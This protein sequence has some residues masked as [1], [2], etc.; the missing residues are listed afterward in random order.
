MKF[1]LAALATL[2]LTPST[3]A[4][5]LAE[6]PLS[7][8]ELRSPT[9]LCANDVVSAKIYSDS[10]SNQVHLVLENGP[11]SNNQFMTHEAVTPMSSLDGSQIF[12]SN[13]SAL[14]IYP[15]EGGLEAVLETTSTPVE[16]SKNALRCQSYFETLPISGAVSI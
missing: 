11:I 13:A 4:W 1:F 3:F 7:A 6:Q 15:S 16:S 5:T 9:M 10:Q 8:R 14:T 12:A 2:A